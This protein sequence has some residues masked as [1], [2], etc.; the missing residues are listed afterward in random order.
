MNNKSYFM[1]IKLTHNIGISHEK[2]NK[3]RRDPFKFLIKVELIEY[4]IK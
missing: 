2:N 3:S 4:C 1:K